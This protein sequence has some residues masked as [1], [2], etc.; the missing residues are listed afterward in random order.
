MK[1]INKLS[2][3]VTIVLFCGIATSA[4]S[5]TLKDVFSNNKLPIVYLGIDFSKAKLLDTG[6][7]N[8]IKNRLYASINQLIINEPKK[9]DLKGAFR[10]DN[11][12]YD[13]AAVNKSNA[14]INENEIISTNSA[15]FNRFKEVDIAN[16][17]KNL[18][19][20][21]KTGI[22]ILFVMESMRKMDK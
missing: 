13:F 21:G 9:F 6:D 4:F 17:V 19:L 1:H 15:D 11:I 10:K 20:A 3:L 8:D 2:W 7:S 12:D 16:M 14:Q 22:G 5:Q 18:D